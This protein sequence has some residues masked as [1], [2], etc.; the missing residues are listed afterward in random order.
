MVFYNDKEGIMMK[1]VTKPKLRT[2]NLVPLFFL[3]FTSMIFAADFTPIEDQ[4][5]VTTAN[6]RSIL[7]RRTRT[8][9]SSVDISLTNISDQAVSCPIHAVIQINE[10]DADRIQIPG[11]LGGDG[12]APYST[13]YVSVEPG[14]Q[15]LP[16]QTYTFPLKFIYSSTIRFT[17]TII[18]YAVASVPNAPPT[19]DAGPD[20]YYTLTTGQT[21]LS[22]I[23]D[24]SGS[25]DTD[26]TIN[27][28]EWQG[29]PD[30]ADVVQP[31]V[32]LGPGAHS[33]SLVVSD[34]DEATSDA[35]S[36]TITVNVT[37]PDLIGLTEAE[38]E[39][40]IEASLT[41]G[42]I[43]QQSSDTMAAGLVIAQTP[44]G[45]SGVP[46]GTV[47]NLVV[48]SGP[49]RADLTVTDINTSNLV[50]DNES[51]RLSGMA[52]VEITNNGLA[53]VQGSYWLGIF[54]DL[55]S[56]GE[57]DFVDDRLIGATSIDQGLDGNS[58][59][60]IE[61]PVNGEILFR[62]NALYA[63]VD[64]ND[65]IVETNEINNIARTL[66]S[67]V[68]NSPTCVDLS[69]SYLRSDQSQIPAG[70]TI[71][72]R[73]GNSGVLPVDPNVQVSFYNG[74]P[75]NGGTFVDT[76]LS[77]QVLQ[78]GEYE[79]IA[80]IW[81]TPPGG[82]TDV[83]AVV[84]DDGSGAGTVQESNETNNTVDGLYYLNNH[85]PKITSSA[86]TQTIMDTDYIY[87]V[88]AMDADSEVLTFALVTA[89]AQMAIDPGTGL[90]TWTS[91]EIG[92]FDVSV[93]VSDASGGVATQTYSLTV[94]S[95][96]PNTPPV[97]DAGPDV[98]VPLSNGGKLVVS[99]DE[100]PMSDNGFISYPEDTK[101]FV[102]NVADYFTGGRPGHFLIYSTDFSY[103]GDS[104]EDTLTNAGHTV[105][106]DMNP[107]SLEVYD[108]VFTGGTS[109][110][111][112]QFTNISLLGAR[113]TLF[114]ARPTIHSPNMRTGNNF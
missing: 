29:S 22:V 2:L 102:L 83:Y 14:E 88:E 55:N 84:D 58:S 65:D 49:A 80:F 66:P 113:F 23:L 77:S 103:I 108:A 20:A 7:D 43:T 28:Y 105:T 96:T 6:T 76:V 61:V 60:T 35:D 52:G 37:V 46:E 17:Y 111:K 39:S 1:Y 41:I 3:F 109:L 98:S 33:F 90:I 15:F 69:A 40:L 48:S 24:G 91:T 87:D 79:D 81:N 62:N 75:L 100:Y 85:L 73:L 4:V 72:V 27:T 56:N 11:A 34:D 45:G 68:T 70:V 13:Y 63:F 47:I 89:P 106:R 19:A 32:L 36:V 18:P 8:I 26:G 86:V 51:M 5:S 107:D 71:T 16:D 112:Q 10:A 9:T 95:P 53:A 25:S 30:P 97:A 114:S 21:S 67:C 92:V 31:T 42:T 110:T 50:L 59:Q 57:F 101:R 54:E 99:S 74:D 93:R 12:I 44:V 64:M 38:A 82:Q 78:P 94:S 104:F